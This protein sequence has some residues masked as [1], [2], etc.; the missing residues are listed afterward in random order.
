ME[1]GEVSHIV[2]QN[3]T[4]MGFRKRNIYKQINHVYITK[5]KMELVTCKN[6]KKEYPS[7]VDKDNTSECPKC[8]DL[9]FKMSVTYTVKEMRK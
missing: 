2:V 1:S 8:N 4:R 5:I 7:S 3:E 6:C 9:G